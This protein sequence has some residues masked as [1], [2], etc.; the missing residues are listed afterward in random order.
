LNVKSKGITRQTFSV[1]SRT[2]KNIVI[3]KIKSIYI[4]SKIHSQQYKIPPRLR[5]R[6]LLL[7][8]QRFNVIFHF[9]RSGFGTKAFAR[10]TSVINEKLAKVPVHVER[11]IV[12]GELTLQEAKNFSCTFSVDRPF[13]KKVEFVSGV[14]FIA[15]L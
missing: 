15:E 12:P 2:A 14:E 8:Q 6:F 7:L 10:R 11:S 5:R 9:E 4:S 3:Q 1:V 13:L